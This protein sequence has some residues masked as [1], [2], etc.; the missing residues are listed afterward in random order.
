MKGYIK[1][2][3]RCFSY[4]TYMI[5]RLREEQRVPQWI[6]AKRMNIS[7]Q[8]YA[9]KEDTPEEMSLEEFFQVA[10]LLGV[11]AEDLIRERTG[12]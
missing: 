11:R 7:R 3:D 5:K 2:H 10:D 1:N 12:E 8:T 6:M 4:L 9:K